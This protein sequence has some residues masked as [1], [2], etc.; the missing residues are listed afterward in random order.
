MREH[1]TLENDFATESDIG[2]V[3]IHCDDV[4]I[5]SQVSAF[6]NSD[7][8]DAIVQFENLIV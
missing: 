6:P 5:T 7:V 3:A 4:N 8:H 1:S 2:F